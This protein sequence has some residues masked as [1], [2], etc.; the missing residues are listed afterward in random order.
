[1]VTCVGAMLLEP[2]MGTILLITHSMVSADKQNLNS[3]GDHFLYIQAAALE[4]EKGW[5][6]LVVSG[7]VVTVFSRSQGFS[8]ISYYLIFH[9]FFTKPRFFTIIRCEGDF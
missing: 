5:A 8:Y 6:I 7:P 1:M 9:L 4:S 2:L 3:S